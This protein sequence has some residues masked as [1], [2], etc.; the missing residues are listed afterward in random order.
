MPPAQRLTSWSFTRLSVYELCPR[1]AKHKFI[2][3]IPEPPAPAL[4]RGSEI[5]EESEQY[6]KGL[7][8]TVPK[9]L[10]AF[11]DEFKA[12]RKRYAK[13]A[14]A[15]AFAEE[16]WGYTADWKGISPRDWV[17]C[18]LRIKVD[19]AELSDPATLDVSDWKTGKFR[20]QKN[21][22]Y[23]DQLDLYGVGGFYRFPDVERVRARLVYLDEGRIFPAGALEDGRPNAVE[24]GWIVYERKRDA[25]RLRKSFEKRIKPM[26][27]DARFAPRPSANACRFC[28]Y[29]QS[30][31]GPCAFG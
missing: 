20:S 11:S 25:E 24:D 9:S 21:G 4:E 5:H 18:K 29:G 23:L 26:L 19:F 6:I 13:G 28:P 17:N 3:K 22:E 8:R 31:G 27:T 1:Q 10:A 7:G 2:D 30:K 12:I 16:S 14:H 15:T